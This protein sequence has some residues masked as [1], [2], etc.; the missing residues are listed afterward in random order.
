MEL[1]IGKYIFYQR[2]NYSK[3]RLI[4][5]LSGNDITNDNSRILQK[6]LEDYKKQLAFP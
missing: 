2:T 6:M 5:A 4:D 3:P 1:K